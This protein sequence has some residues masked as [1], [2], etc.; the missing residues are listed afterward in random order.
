MSRLLVFCGHVML[1][2]RRAAQAAFLSFTEADVRF[3]A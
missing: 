1:L 2:A 3:W